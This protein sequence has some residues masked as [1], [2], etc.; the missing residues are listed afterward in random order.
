[1]SIFDT[2]INDIYNDF[3]VF[4]TGTIQICY[5]YLPFISYNVVGEGDNSVVAQQTASYLLKSFNRIKKGQ[6]TSPMVKYLEKSI[7]QKKFL[8]A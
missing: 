8:I 1:M 2:G 4:V 5:K 6:P 3:A 7:K